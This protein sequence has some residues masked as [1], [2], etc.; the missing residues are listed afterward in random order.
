M[1]IIREKTVSSL[2]AHHRSSAWQ[3]VSRG[4]ILFS[5]SLLMHRERWF[6][7]IQWHGPVL[8]VRRCQIAASIPMA[9]FSIFASC[10]ALKSWPGWGPHLRLCCK[11]F[12]PGLESPFRRT[13]VQRKNI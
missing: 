11:E 12:R 4:L 5:F 10:S 2:G 6:Y 8:L 7:R 1:K 3:R 13:W 9:L